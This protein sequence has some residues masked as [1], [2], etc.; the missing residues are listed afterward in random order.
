[1]G[2]KPEEENILYIY[3]VVKLYIQII[4]NKYFPEMSTLGKCWNFSWLR[5][6]IIFVCG[7]C[8]HIASCLISPVLTQF[9]PVI[10]FNLWNSENTS[11]MSPMELNNSSKELLAYMC[12]F[13]IGNRGFFQYLFFSIVVAQ[14]N[15]LENAMIQALS[16]SQRELLK[17][18][19][20]HLQFFK[21]IMS[22]HSLMTLQMLLPFWEKPHSALS[23]S[24]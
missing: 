12:V 24:A 5:T 11:K 6:T 16:F 14:V 23:Y 3:N 9:M 18:T 21:C 22:L 2:S 13:F 20:N 4:L 10:P 8:L 7:T 17:V 15:G 19:P 1:M